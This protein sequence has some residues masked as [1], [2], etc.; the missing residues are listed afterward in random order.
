M[1][2]FIP[3]YIH[4]AFSQQLKYFFFNL[5]FIFFLL[6]VYTIIYYEV[7]VFLPS[8]SFR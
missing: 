7:S 8:H 5:F 3:S 4:P 2:Y 1:G 6:M